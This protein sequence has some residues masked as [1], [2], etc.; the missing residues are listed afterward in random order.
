MELK[1]RC[2]QCSHPF[3]RFQKR[4]C[5]LLSLPASRSQPHSFWPLYPSSKPARLHIFDHSS[6]VIFPSDCSRESLYDFKDPCNQVGPTQIIRI[7]PHL[8]NL[9]LITPANPLFAMQG[10]ISTGPRDQDVDIL[11]ERSIILATMIIYNRR[12]TPSVKP[13]ALSIYLARM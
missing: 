10:N 4:I 6:V 3:W 13:M 7:M 12:Y 9:N 2:Q 8:K 1:L 11:R 5:F